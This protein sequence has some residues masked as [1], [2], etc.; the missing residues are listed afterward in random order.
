MVAGVRTWA[1][2]PK[3]DSPD[4]KAWPQLQ[5]QANRPCAHAWAFRI[6]VA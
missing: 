4:A 2:G 3:L 5:E 6:R 1:G